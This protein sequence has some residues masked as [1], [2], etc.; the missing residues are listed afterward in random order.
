MYKV[1]DFLYKNGYELPDRSKEEKWIADFRGQH[2]YIFN[3]NVPL[4][5]AGYTSIMKGKPVG[6]F[7]VREMLV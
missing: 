1:A 5:L 2:H 4:S 6:K 3:Q 7:R